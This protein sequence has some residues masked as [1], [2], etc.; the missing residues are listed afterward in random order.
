MSNPGRRRQ[1]PAAPV[2]G[3]VLVKT[4]VATDLRNAGGHGVRG[5]AGTVQAVDSIGLNVAHVRRA[6]AT[7][8]GV[9]GVAG[10]VPAAADIL[11]VRGVAVTPAIEHAPL[12]EA[13]SAVREDVD[14]PVTTLADATAPRAAIDTASTTAL[15]A[16]DGAPPAV[17]LVHTSHSLVTVPLR[18]AAGRDAV[19]AVAI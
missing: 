19:A 14:T 6:A 9:R 13:A 12:H 8:G 15:E 10:T 16:T 3:D 1:T 2:P 4:A 11:Q 18:H 5:D 17:L 7:F